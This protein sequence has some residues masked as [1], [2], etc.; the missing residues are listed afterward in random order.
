M[1]HR[2]VQWGT[3]NVGR[4][5]LRAIIEHPHLELAGVIVHSADKIGRD[6]AELC[7]LDTPTGVVATD[8]VDGLL[9][10]NPD[11]V[12]YMATGDLRPVEAVRDLCRVLSAGVNVVNT[13]VVPLVYPPAADARQVRM[14][15]EACAEGGSSCF[16][17]G[18]DP[19]FANDLL[20]LT[21][22]GMCARVESVRIQENLNYDTYDQAEVLFGMFGFGKPLD[23]TPLIL[24][25]GV[26]RITWGPTVQM[27]A[28]ALDVQLDDIAEVH[29]RRPATETFDIPT[30]TIEAGTTGALRFE[31][32]GIV[33]GRPAIVLEHVTRLRDDLAPEWPAP[34]EGGGY[35]IEIVGD[36]CWTME[37][38][39]RGADGDHNTGGLLAT[40]MRLLN[41]IPAVCAAP[42]GLLTP[43]DLPLITGRGLLS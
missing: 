5:A 1:M 43:T 21:L 17:S 40:A 20:P 25:P 11:V 36:P 28:N 14:L 4:L 32:Q 19:G 30:G 18:I 38:G 26:L 29:E 23:E 34:P 12:S 6:A 41:A 33:N 15:E 10:E 24:S 8:D 35:R 16:T 3:G 2:V 37:L 9:A 7:A 42:P 13:A 22:T 31:V 39:M 27:I